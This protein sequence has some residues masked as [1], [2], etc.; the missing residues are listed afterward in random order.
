MTISNYYNH[1]NRPSMN[2]AKLVL[3]WGHFR[4]LRSDSIQVCV[5]SL[6]GTRLITIII[7]TQVLTCSHALSESMM[8]INQFSCSIEISEKGVQ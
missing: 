7:F 3:F 1:D 5:L 6:S 2:Y 8:S 4:L